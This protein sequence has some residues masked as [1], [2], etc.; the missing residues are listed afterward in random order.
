MEGLGEEDGIVGGLV[1]EG[2][3]GEVEEDGVGVDALH[4][5]GYLRG[6]PLYFVERGFLG[7]HDGR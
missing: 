6:A 3:L 5:H 2:G 7:G 4:A 1:E